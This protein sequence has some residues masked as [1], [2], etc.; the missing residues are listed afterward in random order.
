MKSFED[1]EVYKECRKLRRNVSDFRKTLPKDEKYRLAD[2]L[3]R[4]SRAITAN[5]AEGHGRYHYQENIQF[6]RQARGSL[7]ETLE[8]LIC[9]LDEGYIQEQL[10]SEF[11]N[12][13]DQCLK[14]LNGYISYL[15][16]QKMS[17]LGD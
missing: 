11:R 1:L 9:A 3:L 4:C 2:Q 13:Y 10:L 6:C 7:S 8:H 15:K 5:I 17:K 16:K 14:L 12:S